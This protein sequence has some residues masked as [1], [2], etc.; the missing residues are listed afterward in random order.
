MSIRTE[1]QKTWIQTGFIC[2]QCQIVTDFN[3][4]SLSFGYGS[5]NLDCT[6]EFHF[7]SEECIAALFQNRK[8]QNQLKATLP[9][10]W[11]F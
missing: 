5:E 8:W 10:D 2:D 1:L 4:V 6:P 7:C 11:P 9:K 3:T